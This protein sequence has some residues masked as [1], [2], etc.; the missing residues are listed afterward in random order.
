MKDRRHSHIN[1]GGKLRVTPGKSQS[2][3]SPN[4]KLKPLLPLPPRLPKSRKIRPI[5]P[6]ATLQEIPS[7][8][9][10]SSPIVPQIKKGQHSNSRR[11]QS[12]KQPENNRLPRAHKPHFKIPCS[13]EF[14]S[15]SDLI[16]NMNIASP[17]FFLTFSEHISRIRL[18]CIHDFQTLSRGDLSNPFVNLIESRPLQ[19]VFPF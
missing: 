17:P 1:A 6:K 13:T 10:L 19:R 2:A 5:R 15:I 9:I 11:T 8:T 12:H 3:Q 4:T 14:K 7:A 18:D 16:N